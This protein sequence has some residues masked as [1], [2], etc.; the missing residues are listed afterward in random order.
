M[1]FAICL[2][3][4]FECVRALFEYGRS[5]RI[6]VNSIFIEGAPTSV[7]V[8]LMTT[9]WS[10]V[11]TRS[12]AALHGVE[13]RSGFYGTVKINSGFHSVGGRPLKRDVRA[14]MR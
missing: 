13:F 6:G 11:H 4:F 9:R 8:V 10:S 1:L 3:C 14:I 5:S 2:I 7:R 12:I